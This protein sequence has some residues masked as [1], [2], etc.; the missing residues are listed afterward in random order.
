AHVRNALAPNTIGNNNTAVG[1]LALQ[2]S[3][4]DYNTALGAGAGTH[5]DI[6]SNNIYIGDQGS[7]GATN[8]IAIGGIPASGTDYEACFISGIAG[9]SVNIGTAAPCTSIPTD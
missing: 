5:T 2:N 8:V 3:T 7:A 1:D 6:V 9:A 4:G